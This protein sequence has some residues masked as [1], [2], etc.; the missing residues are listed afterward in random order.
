[1]KVSAARLAALGLWCLGVLPAR[2][3]AEGIAFLINA[4]EA[5]VSLFDVTTRQEL[6]RVPVLREPHHMALTP[7][8]KSLLIGDTVAN[9]M[10]FFDPAT[11]AVQR[12]MTMSDPY[13]FTF[14]PDGRYLTV[15]A[16]AR[17]QIDIYDAGEFRLLHRIAARS[18]PSHINYSPDS[19]TVFVSL[20]GTD[21][22]M[23]VDVQSGK[24]LWTARIGSAPA[25]VLWHE[26]RLLVGIMGADYVAVVDPRDGR[27]ERKVRTGRGAHVLFVPADRKVIYV[28]NRVDGTVSVLDPQTLAVTRSFR[29]PGGPDDMDFGPD[30]KIWISQRWSSGLAIYDP[31]AGTTETLKA[32]RSPHGIWLNTPKSR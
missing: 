8:G 2:A 12:R 11:G 20:Q 6:R 14:S 23:A 1:M 19:R 5:T 13:Q 18:M 28:S 21:S 4:N 17:A 27:V 7:D 10:F 24:P 22:L 25:G 16:L 15:A 30:G 32:G 26:G 31:V 29:I 9:T 3:G